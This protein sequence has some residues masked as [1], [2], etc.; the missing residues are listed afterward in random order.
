MKAIQTAEKRKAL[1]DA[2]HG[3]TGKLKQLRQQR[4][5]QSLPFLEAHG[6]VDTTKYPA[7]FENLLVMWGEIDE[8][9]FKT[10]LHQWLQK[11]ND[12]AV[13]FIDLSDTRFDS[14]PLALVHIRRRNYSNTYIPGGTVGD[15]RRYFNQ[16]TA[17]IREPFLTL[18]F[19]PKLSRY[20]IKP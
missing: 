20:P 4:H 16:S 18:C 17:S 3:Q 9:P 2:L 7:E 14:V 15:L 6:V 12:M 19:N 5:E 11:A 8:K 1:Q 13:G 10:P